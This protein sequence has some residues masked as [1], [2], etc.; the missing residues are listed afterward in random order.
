MEVLDLLE[1]LAA[2]PIGLVQ[3][4]ASDLR[5]GA[6]VRVHFAQ[7]QVV[8]L[9]V[10][11][12]V[13]SDHDSQRKHGSHD[14]FVSL[15]QAS[16][17][18]AERSVGDALNQPLDSLLQRSGSQRLQNV[19]IVLLLLILAALLFL[20]SLGGLLFALRGLFL[21]WLLL[22]FTFLLLVS[23]LLFRLF[24]L[25]DLFDSAVDDHNV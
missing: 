2:S 6:W 23:I 21:S 18:I 19:F 24:L 12:L 15:E 17:G 9:V 25:C 10:V 13:L 7:N 3:V 1:C 20:F 8:H 4:A 11:Q 16:S 22:V 5:H 14:D